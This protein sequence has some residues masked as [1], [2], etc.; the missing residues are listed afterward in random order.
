M[1]IRELIATSINFR[2]FGFVISFVYLNIKS[3]IQFFSN[4]FL[5]KRKIVLKN[6]AKIA[7][8]H[9]TNLK[10]KNSKIIVENGVF[11]IGIRFGYYDGGGFDSKRDLCRIHLFNST[12]RINGNVNLYPGV[13]I[14]AY[15]AEISIGDG[16]AINGST[17]IVS[18]KKIDI[19]NHCWFA[20]EV[21]IR[22]NDGHKI[23]YGGQTP[24]HNIVPV[25]IGDHCWLGQRSMILKG[26][27]LGNDVVIAA[28]AVV[29]KNAERGSLV[30]G[31]P[32]RI[33]RNDVQWEK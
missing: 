16:T 29:T 13:R 7:V 4:T 20:R 11:K 18:F 32:A 1:K 17:E 27:N 9:K 2:A 25:K 19:G 8:H 3:L 5:T 33:I 6:D 10:L 15:N 23:S 30:A 31:V 12:L 21:I 22:D 28:G 14:F 24:I 26:V